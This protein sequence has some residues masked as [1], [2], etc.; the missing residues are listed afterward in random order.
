M[1]KICKVFGNGIRVTPQRRL[2]L[3]EG[4]CSGRLCQNGSIRVRRM[5]Y[6]PTHNS[7]PT[8]SK[9]QADEKPLPSYHQ[10]REKAMQQVT[11][12]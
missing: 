4:V 3:N 10:T 2:E 7:T 6:G 11:H 8:Q 1:S 5:D 12:H 9:I